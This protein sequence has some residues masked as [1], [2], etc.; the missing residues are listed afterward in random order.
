MLPAFGALNGGMIARSGVRASFVPM[1][2]SD[3]LAPL[4]PSQKPPL[5]MMKRLAKNTAMQRLSILRLKVRPRPYLPGFG[6]AF[7][8]MATVS[9]FMAALMTV[10][11]QIAVSASGF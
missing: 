9:P 10:V 11:E 7:A 2:N 5:P 8:R 3:G 1:V 6:L 4:P